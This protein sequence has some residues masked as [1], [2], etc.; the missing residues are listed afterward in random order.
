MKGFRLSTLELDIDFVELCGCKVSNSESSK[1]L[2]L[3]NIK[4]I[5]LLASAALILSLN[6]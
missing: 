3:Y 2:E 4:F 1:I 6:T 5:L